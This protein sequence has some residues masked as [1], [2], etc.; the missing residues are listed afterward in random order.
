MV[1]LQSEGGDIICRVL[2]DTVKFYTIN[3]LFYINIKLRELR[4]LLY[5]LKRV[6]EYFENAP[7]NDEIMVSM[8]SVNSALNDDDRCMVLTL[9]RSYSVTKIP[10][11]YGALNKSDTRPWIDKATCEELI[12]FIESNF[13]IH[14]GEPASCKDILSVIKQIKNIK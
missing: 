1:E 8:Y 5:T 14:Y 12:D 3:V 7:D 2:D 11:N 6:Q 4:K 9:D 10:I 13:I